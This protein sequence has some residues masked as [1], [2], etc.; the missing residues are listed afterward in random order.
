MRS[1]L[2]V[3]LIDD[4]AV[5][6]FALI[7]GEG[8]RVPSNNRLVPDWI[9][10]L[11]KARKKP[12]METMLPKIVR[13]CTVKKC[14]SSGEIVAPLLSRHEIMRIPGRIMGRYSTHYDASPIRK[15]ICKRTNIIA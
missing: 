7:A 11:G 6:R 3:N 9:D 4:V 10:F 5:S 13:F 12:I 1:T 2:R 8:A 14:R 15:T